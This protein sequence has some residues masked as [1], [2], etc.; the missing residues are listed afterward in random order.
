[1]DLGAKVRAME[2]R[3]IIGHHSQI[4]VLWHFPN[5]GLANIID[6]WDVLPAL[7]LKRRAP[8]ELAKP[9]IGCQWRRPVQH[10][11][12]SKMIY[13]EMAAFVGQVG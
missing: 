13:D 3:R 11:S 2:L 7:S 9:V 5:M 1:M 6:Q 4:S 8:F 12:P 10:V